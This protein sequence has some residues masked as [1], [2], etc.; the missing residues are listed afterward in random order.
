MLSKDEGLWASMVFIAVH[1]EAGRLRT[2]AEGTGNERGKCSKYELPHR[3]FGENRR[4]QEGQ[5][6]PG[7]GVDRAARRT[8]TCQRAS[9]AVNIPRSATDESPTI[10]RSLTEDA[11]ERKARY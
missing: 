4:M 8:A 7:N 5:D 9:S 1:L 11:Y 3:M 6:E 10:P 2:P